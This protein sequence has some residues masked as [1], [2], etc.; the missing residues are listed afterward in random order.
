MAAPL[1]VPVV[2]AWLLGVLGPVLMSVVGR[3]LVALGIGV[4]TYAGMDVALEA[5]RTQVIQNLGALPAT[6]V[7][8]LYQ[9]KVDQAL[10]IIVSALLGS[11]AMRGIAGSITKFVHKGV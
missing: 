11:I 3:V 5:L 7:T 10:N 4:V 8:V 9:T 2:V 6:I 1:A